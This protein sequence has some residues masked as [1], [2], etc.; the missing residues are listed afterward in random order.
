MIEALAAEATV[1]HPG[2]YILYQVV[3]N[4]AEANSELELR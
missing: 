2:R 1:N 3:L 4:Q